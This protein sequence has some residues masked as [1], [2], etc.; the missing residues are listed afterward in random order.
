MRDTFGGLGHDTQHPLPVADAEAPKR[1]DR[2]RP[3]RDPP[4]TIVATAD[5]VTH[6]RCMVGVRSVRNGKVPAT[7][8][9]GPPETANPSPKRRR[10]ICCD[11]C[12]GPSLALRARFSGL[13]TIVTR[14]PR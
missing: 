12:L 4:P 8:T 13:P 6:A 14:T 7:Y 1:H 5:L 3:A 10:G 2:L 11:L 9:A